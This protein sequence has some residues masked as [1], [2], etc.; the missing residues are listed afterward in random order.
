MEYIVHCMLAVLAA[1]L[2]VG[3]TIFDLPGN[4]FMLATIYAFAFFTDHHTGMPYLFMVTMVYLIGELWEAGMSFFG[5]KRENVSWGTVFII[6][7]GGFIG[8]IYGTIVFPVLGSFIGGVC[9]AFLTAFV[10]TYFTTGDKDNAWHIAWATA[11]VRF[12]AVLGKW[13]AGFA[14]AVLLVGLVFAGG[15][16]L[17]PF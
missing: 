14:L 12:L 15:N 17:L 13:T 10:Y 11:K 5:I 7:I 4:S 6:G 1:M 8:T 2:G 3:L 16:N 9:G